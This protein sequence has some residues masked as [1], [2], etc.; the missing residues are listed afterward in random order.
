MIKI[1][2]EDNTTELLG[3]RLEQ[4]DVI[5]MYHGDKQLFVPV[6]DIIESLCTG[7]TFQPTGDNTCKKN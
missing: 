1:Y 4:D 6:E 7:F 2:N 5:I 3:Y